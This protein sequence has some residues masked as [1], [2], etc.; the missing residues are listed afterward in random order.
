MP[1][2]R[3]TGKYS[4]PNQPALPPHKLAV[5]IA[6]GIR[7]ITDTLDDN[8]RLAQALIDLAMN[9]VLEQTKSL[10]ESKT[11]LRGVVEIAHEMGYKTDDSSRVK[12]GKFVKAQGFAPQKEKRICNGVL[13]PIN[14][15]PDTPELRSA[16]AAYFD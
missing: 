4:L 12:L 8:P 14:C 13:T 7:E 9:Q 5:E 6:H 3:K 1:S 15:Y 11:E 10:P 2:I 16:I